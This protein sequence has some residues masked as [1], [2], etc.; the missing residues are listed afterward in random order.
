MNKREIVPRCFLVTCRDTAVVLDPVHEPLYKVA[1]LVPAFAVLAGL[2]AVAARG[3]HGLGA[4][5]ANR[6]H[7][8]VGVIA[9]VCNYSFRL[10]LPE[11]FFGAGNIVLL[12]RAEAQL[13]WLSLGVYREMKLRAEP[14]ARA[15][16]GFAA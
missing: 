13:Q 7:Q 5:L 4:A 16:E 9:L 15:P 10:V 3:D 8:L 6:L 12:A 1:A 2:L 14:A 11:Q